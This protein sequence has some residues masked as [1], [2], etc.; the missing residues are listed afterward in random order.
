[1]F[2]NGKRG[3]VKVD[4]YRLMLKFSKTMEPKVI[5]VLKELLELFVHKTIQN[6]VG[7]G[8]N[9]V[10][11][12]LLKSCGPKT[13]SSFEDKIRAFFMIRNQ[14]ELLLKVRIDWNIRGTFISNDLIT[15]ELAHLM[16]EGCTLEIK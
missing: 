12:S 14:P 3:Y 15:P 8:S 13:I 11:Q 4:P 2:Y 7:E 9:S 1:M 5:A 16:S 6:N 10:L